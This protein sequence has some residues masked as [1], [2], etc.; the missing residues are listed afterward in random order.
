[1]RKRVGV[2]A[3]DVTGANDIGIMFVKGGYRSAVFPLELIESCDLKKEAEGLDAIIIDT[4]SRFDAPETAK[5]KVRRATELLASLPCDMY[6]NKTCSVFRGNIGAEFDEMQDV[7]GVS[8]SMVVLGFPANGRTTVDGIHYVYGEKLENSQFRHDP[9]HPMTT[10]SLEEILHKQSDRSVGL[11]TWRDLDQ[12]LSHVKEK[13]ERLKKECS[14]VIFDIRSQ[15]DLKL[16]ARAVADEVNVCG[17]SAIGE[18]LPAAYREMDCPVLSVC[19]S[20]TKQ[21]R[22]QVEYLKKKGYPVFELP[23]DVIFSE[24][25]RTAAIGDLS[26]QL[27]RALSQAGCG[28]LHTSNQED[29]VA[30]TKQTGYRL[31]MSDEEVGKRISHTICR[32]VEDVLRESGCRRLVVA[33]GDTSAAVTRQLAICRMEIGKEIEA[34]VPVMKGKTS[35]GELDLVLKSGSFGSEAFLEKAIEAVRGP[36]ER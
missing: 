2:V 4:D 22:S 12:G 10:S 5:E 8:C 6:H 20:L 21:S 36:E 19:G 11:I 30:R 14:Y 17:S 28:L 31:G 24:E 29:A 18:E 27:L 3:D 16:V 9:I 35:L 7:L 15:E 34:G 23:T 1:M 32:I 26:G 33:G 25:E 13:K